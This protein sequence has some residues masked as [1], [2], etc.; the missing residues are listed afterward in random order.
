MSSNVCAK[1]RRKFSLACRRKPCCA[2]WA[3]SSFRFTEIH[4][5]SPFLTTFFELYLL[6][7][8]LMSQDDSPSSSDSATQVA[9]PLEI[10]SP[11][12][13]AQPAREST[14]DPRARLH[15][16]A[17]ELTRTRSRRML[18]EFLQLRRALR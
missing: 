4:Q 9:P 18:I 15:Q 13:A 1:R 8:G 3:T 7:G 12:P 16:L 5:N 6:K 17:A 14:H 2:S 10:S 11:P